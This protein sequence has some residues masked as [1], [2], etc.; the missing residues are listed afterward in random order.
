[1]CTPSLL[2]TQVADP[3]G[4]VHKLLHVELEDKS[5]RAE[6]VWRQFMTQG[7]KK[8]S[9]KK[10]PSRRGRSSSSKQGLEAVVAG[11]TDSFYRYLRQIDPKTLPHGI[12]RLS[13]ITHEYDSSFFPRF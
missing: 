8:A 5:R 9:P 13:I 6:S 1:M 12:R 4:T 3:K 2:C 7:M 11:S 10:S